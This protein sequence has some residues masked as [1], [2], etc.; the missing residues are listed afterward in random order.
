M[1][2]KKPADVDPRDVYNR[3]ASFELA[4]LSLTRSY[5]G[6][7]KALKV[8]IV[9]N[10]AFSLELYLKCLLYLEGKPTKADGH[11]LRNLYGNLDDLHQT[12]VLVRYDAAIAMSP[13]MQHT[14]RRERERTLPTLKW[15]LDSLLGRL[16]NAFS[17]WRYDY[18]L[19]VNEMVYHGAQP[20]REAIRSLILDLRPDWP[21]P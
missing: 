6:G 13:M 18:E 8:P 5:G 15:D 16:N 12:V 2:K 20:V 3:A 4:A 9:V 17:A 21:M 11:S 14:F 7:D 19:T 10:S 1:G